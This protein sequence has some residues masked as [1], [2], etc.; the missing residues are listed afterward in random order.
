[1][2]FALTPIT[3]ADAQAISR[4]SYD[5]PY[6][7]YNGNPAS[8]ASLLQPR[9]LY[10]SVHDGHGELV[11]YFCFG[12]DAR[13]AAGKGVGLYNREDALDVGLG[14]RPD[15]TGRGLGENFV[16][17]GL[18][19]AEDTYSPPAFRL[20]VATFNRRAI[21]VYERAGFERIETFGATR[22]NGEREWLL[23]RR[24][25]LTSQPEEVGGQD[26]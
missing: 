6:A 21:R 7:V 1:L 13:V 16:R 17:A 3:R 26:A 25:R 14:M 10:H 20:T 4:W 9:Y 2:R 5:G 24:A 22:L 18:Q 12:E 11:G 8:V 19:F 15:L 23:M